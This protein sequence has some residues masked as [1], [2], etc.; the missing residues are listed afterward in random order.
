MPREIGQSYFEDAAV[1]LSAR[2]ATGQ[3][4]LSGNYGEVSSLVVFVRITAVS[5][6]TPTLTVAVEDSPN[7]TDWAQVAITASLNAAGLTV[8]RIPLTTPF[9][10]TLRIRWVIGGTT[11]SFTFEVI[12]ASQMALS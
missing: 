10:N 8:L 1:A 5:G 9:G 2:T 6:T 4:N 7:G 12:V 3:Q 11:P